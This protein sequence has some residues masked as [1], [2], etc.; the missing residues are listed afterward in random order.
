MLCMCLLRIV[1]QNAFLSS[2]L[3]LIWQEMSF[4]DVFITLFIP[5]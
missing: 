4:N 1:F 3:L 2:C 5:K